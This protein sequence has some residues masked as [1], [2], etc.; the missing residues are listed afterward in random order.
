[1]IPR[2]AQ[3]CAL[4][5]IVCWSAASVQGQSVASDLPPSPARHFTDKS[6]T[7]LSKDADALDGLLQKYER[8]SGNQFVVWMD[9][10]LPPHTTLE[11]HATRVF[12][13]WGIGQKDRN[14]GVLLLVFIADHKMRL[15]TGLAMEKVL[16]DSLCA[17]IINHEIVPLFRKGEYG[18]GLRAGVEAVIAATHG[19]Y[20]PGI[21]ADEFGL[22]IV[23]GAF[24][25]G[26]GVLFY[27]VLRAFRSPTPLGA[28]RWGTAQS[29]AGVTSASFQTS[30]SG[31]GG[32]YSS[33][34]GGG[35]TGGGGSSGGGGASGGW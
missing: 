35:F 22:G 10:H 25:T 15:E 31:G 34:G 23:L 16:P 4:G 6:H 32:G 17:K 2:L 20:R 21:T 18:A 33:G 5:W 24:L 13:H 19:K 1:M 28:R 9:Q 7:L 29:L 26:L 8:D 27:S 12:N 30:R 3:A 11:A 14:N